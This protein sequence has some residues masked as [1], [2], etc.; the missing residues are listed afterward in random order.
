VIRCQ[1]EMPPPRVIVPNTRIIRAKQHMV[2]N[3]I[4]QAHLCDQTLLYIVPVEGNQVTVGLPQLRQ[5]IRK[6]GFLERL[7]K[8]CPCR[9]SPVPYVAPQYY[10]RQRLHSALG[11]RPPEEFEEQTE[12]PEAVVSSASATLVFFRP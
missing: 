6:N 12:L 8:S 1:N 7:N 11:Y 9:R 10:N 2:C 3:R 4:E 5:V